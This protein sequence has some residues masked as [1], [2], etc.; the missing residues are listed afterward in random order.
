MNRIAVKVLWVAVFAVAAIAAQAQATC[1]VAQLI[2]PAPGSTLP[3]STVTFS[4][5]NAS[6]DYFLDVESILGAH[7]I[8][9]ARVRVTSVTLINLP[10]T[11]RPVFLTLW[12]QGANGNWQ[13]PFQYTFTAASAGSGPAPQAVPNFSLSAS[14]TGFN[15]APGQ[16]ATSTVTMTP[17]NG[18]DGT[19]TLGCAGLPANVTCRFSPA[20]LVGN[21]SPAVAT[22]TVSVAAAVAANQPG[23]SGSL[24]AFWSLGA[25]AFGMVFT[26]ARRRTK[27]WVLLG[28]MLLSIVLLAGC[29]GAYSAPAAQSATPAPAAQ[30]ATPT[31]PQPATGPQT[32]SGAV[33]AAAA[34]GFNAAANPN[35]QF[36]IQV[37]LL[38]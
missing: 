16:S 38:P 36:Q 12:T 10:T 32:V 26:G 33:T 1:P 7:D 3:G 14:T 35:Q 37:T 24:L 25:G 30:P 31:T 19:V 23:R 15:L 9:Y 22:M 20:Q 28:C 17:S 21:G 13:N 11:G 18:F 6:A 5:C 27:C 2:S 8:F 29:G 34:G 4:W